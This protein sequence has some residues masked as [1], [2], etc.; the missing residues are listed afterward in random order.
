MAIQTFVSGQV[1]TA[2]QVTA[3]QSNQ[4]N[5]TVSTKTAS[6]VL[7]AADVG[8]RVVMNAAGATT[9]TVNTSLFSAGDTLRI[10]NIGAGACTITAGTATVNSSTGNLIVR[11]YDSGELYFTSTGVAIFFPSYQTSGLELITACTVTSVGGTS[12]TAS[13]GVVTIGGSNT[14]VTVS[15]AFS[16]TYDNYKIVLSNSVTTASASISMV[17]ANALGPTITGYYWGLQGTSFDATGNASGNSASNTSSW[18]V[19]GASTTNFNMTTEVLSPN[20]AGNSVVFS[21]YLI[22]IASTSGAVGMIGGFLNN[23]TQYTA[24]TLSGGTMS[25]GTIRVYGYKN[26]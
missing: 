22:P 7:V 5:Q 2:A 18:R 13:N 23:S 4:Y 9:I 25:G 26:G 15:S 19:G 3:V 11:Q 8:T 1:L 16:A 21:N 24:F 14:S 10:H 20:L 6:Y 12:A 17:L